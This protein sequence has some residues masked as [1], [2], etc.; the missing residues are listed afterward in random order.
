MIRPDNIKLIR[1]DTAYLYRKELRCRVKLTAQ[2]LSIPKMAI[3]IIILSLYLKISFAQ[4]DTVWT[5]RYNGPGNGEDKACAVA[6]DYDGDIYVTGSSE[7]VGSFEDYAT[8]KY[9]MT[10]D[11]IWVKRYDGPWS[12]TDCPI[13]LILDNSNNVYVCG[14][15]MGMDATYDYATIKYNS[16]GDTL[17]IRLLNGLWGDHD[18]ASAFFVD[19]SGNVYVTGVTRAAWTDQNYMTVKYNASGDTT[20]VRIYNHTA[21]KSDSATNIAI[22]NDGNVYVIGRSW[23]YVTRDDYATVK[24]DVN[25]N[26]LWVSRYN[27]ISD[28][29][30]IAIAVVVDNN[31]N[32]YVS[33][34]SWTDG[35]GYDIV[36]I[37]YHDNGDT[38]WTRHY[39]GSGN[40]NDYPTKM[41]LDGEG[42][43]YVIAYTKEA[44]TDYCTI[45]YDSDGNEL[46]VVHYN[47]NGNGVDMAYA[48]ALDDSG[49]IYV[50]GT[51]F[52]SGTL[53]DYATIK[54]DAY[55]N[56]L[57]VTRYSGVMNYGNDKA[58]SIAVDSAGYVYVTGE[59]PNIGSGADYVTIKYSQDTGIEENS[60]VKNV[61]AA[62]I[63]NSVFRNETEI[64]YYLPE[65][66]RVS[67]QVYDIQGRLIKKLVDNSWQS[68][69]FVVRWAGED[70]HGRQSSAGIYLVRLKTSHDSLTKKI[71]KLK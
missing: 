26:E 2:V 23:D 29:T 16:S 15:S 35:S 11:S 21:D 59:S 49:N 56:E 69:N 9:N 54:Y 43:I 44:N 39:N 36:T 17:W 8:I 19:D 38:L 46:W 58:Y 27:G 47:G 67:L 30:D 33:G 13:G 55:G 18:Y 64:T 24:Y 20:W 52:G 62:M 31:N 6:I 60:I 48:A 71:I 51:S 45:K 61:L 7:G 32:I 66:D 50:T 37:R 34:A 12:G 22:D 63:R 65:P 14:F 68:G 10:G 4:I 53:Y 41:L 42:N 70:D 28:S 3:L 57:W 1:S 25:G 40:G 5:N